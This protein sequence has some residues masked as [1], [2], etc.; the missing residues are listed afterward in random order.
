MATTTAAKMNTTT[1]GKQSFAISNSSTTIS[2]TTSRIN[3]II[4]NL[5]NR[6]NTSTTN[7]TETK[8]IISSIGDNLLTLSKEN[9]NDT[10]VLKESFNLINLLIETPDDI[11][12]DS[13]KTSRSSAS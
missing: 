12:F 13:Q 11:L 5:F 7:V 1:T 10:N 6:L 2:T 8:E 9:K 4:N 3:P